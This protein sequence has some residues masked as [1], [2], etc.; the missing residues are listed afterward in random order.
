MKTELLIH[1]LLQC[2]FLYKNNQPNYKRV[3]QLW[4]IPSVANTTIKKFRHENILFRFYQMQF[5]LPEYN[6]YSLAWGS[7]EI[8]A[9]P[10]PFDSSWESH[11]ARSL[12]TSLTLGSKRSRECYLLKKKQSSHRSL[13]FYISILCFYKDI[14]KTTIKHCGRKENSNFTLILTPRQNKYFHSLLCFLQ[15]WT[16]AS[17]F[18]GS[19]S[20]PYVW[21][22]SISGINSHTTVPF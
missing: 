3:Q 6:L 17:G 9:Q 5:L 16:R 20:F 11:D 1:H 4:H 2:S 18:T 22:Q 21:F 13:S 8:S 12:L 14:I 10:S 7:V 15:F 19:S